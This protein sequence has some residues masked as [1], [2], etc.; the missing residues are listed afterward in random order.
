MSWNL[1]LYFLDGKS[2]LIEVDDVSVAK[3][4]VKQLEERGYW[5]DTAKGISKYFSSKY[6]TSADLWEEKK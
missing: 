6:L 2:D 5:K 1:R 3:T 4:I